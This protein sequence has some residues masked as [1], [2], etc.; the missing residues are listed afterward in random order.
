MCNAVIQ[1]KN[2]NKEISGTVI[3]DNINLNIEEGKSYGIIGANGSGK[4][5]LFKAICGLIKATSGEIIV[6]DKKI[7]KGQLPENIGVIIEKPG[8]LPHYSGFKNLK[9]LASINN[10]VDDE[11]IRKVISLVGLSPDDEKPIQKYSLGMKQRLGIA[12]ALMEKPKILLLDEPM[13]G[14]DEDGVEEI[15]KILM[16]LNKQ[17][18]TLIMTSHN[19]EDIEALCQ[20]VY[21]MSSGKLNKIIN[22]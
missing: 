10:V 6:L 3:L 22:N 4:S 20:E 12:Q 11:D 21:K 18:V 15:R 2:L 5:M 8:F 14:L 1:I 13:N 19:K 16:D 9:M 17:N 7:H